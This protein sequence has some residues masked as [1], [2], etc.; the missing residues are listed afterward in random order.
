MSA[1][2]RTYLSGESIQAKTLSRWQHAAGEK[3]G[4][5]GLMAASIWMAM[6]CAAACTYCATSTLDTTPEV[7][8]VLSPP[9]RAAA[10]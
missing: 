9:T 6:R 1:H 3:V 7:M 4:L 2:G 8:L 10:G 5:P